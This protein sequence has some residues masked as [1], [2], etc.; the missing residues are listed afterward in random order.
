MSSDLLH[1]NE[2]PGGT[3]LKFG[4]G[5]IRVPVH[6]NSHPL[7]HQVDRLQQGSHSSDPRVRRW[8]RRQIDDCRMQKYLPH[9][10]CALAYRSSRTALAPCALAYRS[11][12]TALAPCALVLLCSCALVLLRL[13]PLR[14]AAVALLWQRRTPIVSSA[15]SAPF[16]A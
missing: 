4:A 16:A 5:K 3:P 7:D 8:I 2:R 12:R 14:P 9:A 15:P 10:P 13:A 1:S 11:S 6:T